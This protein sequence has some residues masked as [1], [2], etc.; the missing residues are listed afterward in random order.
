[1][2]TLEHTLRGAWRWGLGWYGRLA[3]RLRH[4]RLVI[5]WVA[6]RPIVVLPQVF[7]PKLLRSGAMLAGALDER[8]VPE[9]AAVL[10]MG[11]GSGIGAVFAARRARRVVAVDINPEAV[12][13]ARINALLNRVEGRVEVRQGDLFAPLAGERFDVVLFN[14]PFF[15]GRPQDLLDHAWRSVDVAERFAAGL[16]AHLAPGGRALVILSSDGDERAFLEAFRA[17]E[18]R[19]SV[20]ARRDL[21]N[22]ILTIY[23]IVP[24]R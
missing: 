2:L 7:N 22:E 6:G 5:E 8:L 19:V 1:M 12:R 24:S 10:D 16:A 23:A 4:N 11:T 20:A 14:P 21:W 18:L 3:G 9:G 13:C 17:H 15:R